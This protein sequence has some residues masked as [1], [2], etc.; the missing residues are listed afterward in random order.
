MPNQ[1]PE[2]LPAQIDADTRVVTPAKGAPA[3]ALKA[4]RPKQIFLVLLAALLINGAVVLVV[5]PKFGRVVAANYSLDLQDLYRSIA[6]NLD[7]GN[8]YRVYATMSKTML[9]EPVYPLFLAGIFKLFGDNMLTARIASVLLAFGAALMLLRLARKLT[10]D[11]SIALAAAVLFL[12]Y[13]GIIVAETRAGIEIPCI[14]TVMLFMLA[15]HRAVEQG[16]L[17]RYGAAGLLLGAAA[18]VRSE[19]VLFPLFLMVYLVLVERSAGERAKAVLRIAV[20]ALGATIVMSPWIIRNY[21][22]VHSFVPTSTIAGLAAQAGLY[23]CEHRVPGEPFGVADGDAG[24]Q[25]AEIARQLGIPI[26]GPYFEIF[27]TPQGELEL[28]HAL[29]K[30]VSAKY[31]SH[32]EL[33]A[34]CA[35]KNVF[36]N[37]WFLGKTRKATLLN[38]LV[39]APLLALALAGVVVLWKR[40]LLCN[41]AII[42]LFILYI[43]AVHAP[44]VSEARY[45]MFVVPFLAILAAAFLVWAWRKTGE[46]WQVRA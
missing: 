27:Y 24:L 18:M 9:R 42:L 2:H 4:L 15:L 10:G 6:R 32:P 36:F 16:S 11:E 29:L 12:L 20:L 45:S 30:D 44:L 21:R 43:P 34:G 8:G 39:Q 46:K 40:K 37:L 31:L 3:P 35:A 26:V 23:T 5:V 25:R 28:D 17:W 13:P 33:L 19:V 14:L 41:A 1:T 7:Q 22:L 38:V